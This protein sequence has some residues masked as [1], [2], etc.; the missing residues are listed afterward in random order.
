[1]INSGVAELA[2]APNIFSSF[3]ALTISHDRF[4]PNHRVLVFDRGGRFNVGAAPFPN[5]FDDG[6]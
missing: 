5:L 3:N 1:M 2:N 6:A 4:Q